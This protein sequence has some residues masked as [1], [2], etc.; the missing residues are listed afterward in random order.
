M[1]TPPLSSQEGPGMGAQRLCSM[2]AEAVSRSLSA[3]WNAGHHSFV[4]AMLWLLDASMATSTEQQVGREPKASQPHN[5]FDE[6]HTPHE[7]YH[8]DS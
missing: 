5:F 4:Q 1:P 7:S 8:N 6:P 2:L 3:R